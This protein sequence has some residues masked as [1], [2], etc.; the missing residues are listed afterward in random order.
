M[1]LCIAGMHRS[2]TSMITRMLNLCGV[3]LGEDSEMLGST[4]S[5]PKGHWEN[6][7]MMNIN[8][9]LLL[10]FGGAWDFPPDLRY[11]WEKRRWVNPVRRKALDYAKRFD[12]RELWGWKDPRNSLT[13]PFWRSCFPDLKVLVCVRNPMDVAR[14]LRKRGAS[15]FVF[16]VELW[17]DYHDRLLRDTDPSTRLVTHFDSFFADPGTELGRIFSW[18]GVPLDREKR[19]AAENSVSK[20]LHH[21]Q[22]GGQ[23]PLTARQAETAIEMYN[24][25]CEEAGPVFEKT[26][27]K[28]KVGSGRGQHG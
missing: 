25:L 26:G 1:P 23:V 13:I 4:P 24:G 6:V 10:T 16:G 28:M 19:T 2:G 20:S 7:S 9:E 27:R 5:N 11:G 18:L 21:G 12:G 8:R 15:S 14:S 3:Y 22:G 17:M